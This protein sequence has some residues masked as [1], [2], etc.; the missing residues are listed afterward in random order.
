MP[1]NLSLDRAA[2]ATV[3]KKT[4]VAE[5]RL[6]IA[7]ES[8]SEDEPLVGDLLHVNSLGFVGMLVRIEDELDAALPDNLFVGRSFRTVGDLIDVVTT[9]EA[10][11]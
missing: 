6:S 1:P 5:S 10:T 4:V 9:A 11:R 7:P 3:V 8:V 2:V